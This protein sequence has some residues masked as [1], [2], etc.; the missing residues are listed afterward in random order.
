MRELP[1]QCAADFPN[2]AEWRDPAKMEARR[3]YIAKLISEPDALVLKKLADLCGDV[4]PLD[5]LGWMFCVHGPYQRREIIKGYKKLIASIQK[6][7]LK[8]KNHV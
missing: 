4:W 6:P 8:G 3:V 7:T 5:L 2:I 1:K